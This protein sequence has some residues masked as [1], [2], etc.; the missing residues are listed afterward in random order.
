[1]A[2]GRV[3]WMEALAIMAIRDVQ[4]L[5]ACHRMR[6]DALSWSDGVFPPDLVLA[7]VV[8]VEAYG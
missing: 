3:L 2:F 7:T 5:V 1:M 4:S 8:K 6:I